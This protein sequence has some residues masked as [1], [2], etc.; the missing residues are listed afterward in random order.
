MCVI[1]HGSIAL[2]F[3]IRVLYVSSDCILVT[4]LCSLYNIGFEYGDQHQVSMCYVIL[5]N[6]GGLVDSIY[7]FVGG[8]CSPNDEFGPPFVRR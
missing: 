2:W 3:N 6:S 4:C 8:W 7:L 5:V 1:C